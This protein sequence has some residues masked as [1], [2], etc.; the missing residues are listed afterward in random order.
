MRLDQKS[1][2]EEK[3]FDNEDQDRSMNTV[4]EKKDKPPKTTSQ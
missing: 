2:E 4:T 3:S 1:L